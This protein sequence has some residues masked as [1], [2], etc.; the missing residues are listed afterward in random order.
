MVDL[1]FKVLLK[2]GVP[3]LLIYDMRVMKINNRIYSEGS[4]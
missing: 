2:S 4:V 1:P 3:S